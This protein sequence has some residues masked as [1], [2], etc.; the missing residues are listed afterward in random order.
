VAALGERAKDLGLEP[1]QT[2]KQVT[3]REERREAKVEEERREEE[4][5]EEVDISAG[6][7]SLFGF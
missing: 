6:L 5:E 7:E 2:V 4:K 1:V 3:P